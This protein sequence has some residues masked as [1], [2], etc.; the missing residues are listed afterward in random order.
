M[1]LPEPNEVMV[2]IPSSIKEMLLV[3]PLIVDECPMA[4][5]LSPLDIVLT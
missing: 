3:P 1:M 4:M 5:L 2:V